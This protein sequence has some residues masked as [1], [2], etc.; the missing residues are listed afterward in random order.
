MSW[1]IR[2]ARDEDLDAVMQLERASFPTDA[3]SSAQMAGEF[4]SPYGYYVVVEATD[5][6]D[7]GAVAGAGDGATV[8]P[9][10]VGYAGFSSLPGGRDGD[11]QTIAVAAG[12]RGQGI[13]RALFQDLLDEAARR[14][15]RDVFLEVRADNPVAQAM[16]R[17]FGF[18]QIGTRPRYYQPDDVD[19]LVMRGTVPDPTTGGTT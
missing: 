19:A 14:G 18:E 13:G 1:R 12:H 8:A 7:A 3:W 6:P 16:Y 17:A 5:G 4:A 15:V 9:A 2:P 10:V 11:V